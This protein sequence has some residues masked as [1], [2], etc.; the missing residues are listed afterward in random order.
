M[1]ESL[2][3]LGLD[4][5]DIDKWKDS[6]AS[7]LYPIL[8]GGLYHRTS[9]KNYFGIK[10]DGYIYP[11]TGQYDCTYP[12]SKVYYG[13]SKG[14][15]SLFDFANA[16]LKECIIMHHAW[17]QFFF[18]QD[19]VTIVLKL[20]RDDLSYKLIP[21]SSAPRERPFYKGHIH[22]VEAWYPEPIKFSSIEEFCISFYLDGSPKFIIFEK[23][24]IDEFENVLSVC[25]STENTEQTNPP[26][27]L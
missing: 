19:P 25:E 26:D 21:N 2:Y 16:T 7:R 10:Q 14:F 3:N 12:Q 13:Y 18:D 1:D 24:I 5:I 4:Q 22:Y 6:A 11:N 20:N 17:N 9:V 15:I 27:G 23:T 8:K